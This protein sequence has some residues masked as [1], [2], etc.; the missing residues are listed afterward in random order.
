MKYQ[1]ITDI[2]TSTTNTPIRTGSPCRKTYVRSIV[3]LQS[4]MNRHDDPGGDGL[5]ATL[6][7]NKTPLPHGADR[8]AI[9]SAVCAGLVDLDLLRFAVRVHEHAQQHCALLAPG[10]GGT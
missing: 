2:R 1:V 9:Q 7:R 10:H 4:K 8:G 6:G 3:S 5:V